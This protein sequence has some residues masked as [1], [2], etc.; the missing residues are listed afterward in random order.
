MIPMVPFLRLPEGPDEEAYLLGSKCG[1]CGETYLGRRAICVNCF[2]ADSM[3]EV[4]LSRTGELFTYTVVYQSAPWVKVPYA[5]VVVKLPEGP[6]V[7]ASL[8]G[9]EPDPEA[10][11]VGMPVEMVT[12]VVREDED[13]NQTIAYK[14]K[15]TAFE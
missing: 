1:G 6:L 3:E 13:G 14:F 9:S 4:R 2:E 12:E 11:K 7:R 5:A 8:T 10:L 15:L